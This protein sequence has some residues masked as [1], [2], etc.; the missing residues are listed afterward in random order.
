MPESPDRCRRI[1]LAK[2]NPKKKTR[3]RRETHCFE[4]VEEVDVT[5]H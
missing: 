2:L 4:G 3:G 1:D 5:L